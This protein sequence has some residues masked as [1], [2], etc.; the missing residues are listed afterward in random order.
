MTNVKL[1]KNTQSILKNFSTL[2]SNILINEGNIIK[3]MSPQKNVMAQAVVEESF[4]VD[5]G[6]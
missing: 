5:F 1:T 3:T 2:N 4:P 6:I